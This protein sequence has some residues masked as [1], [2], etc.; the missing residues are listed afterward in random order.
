ML[1]RDPLGGEQERLRASSSSLFPSL[2]TPRTDRPSMID[3]LELGQPVDEAG[4]GRSRS[5]RG[6]ALPVVD[7]V[8][9][10]L[11][12][13]GQAPVEDERGVGRQAQ[14]DLELVEVVAVGR[15]VADERLPGV[16]EARL[17][18]VELELR[19]ARRLALDQLAGRPRRAARRPRCSCGRSRR[20][21]RPRRTLMKP[22]VGS[23]LPPPVNPSDG[24]AEPKFGIVPPTRVATMNSWRNLA[25]ERIG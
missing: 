8:E 7:R 20:S 21:G 13:A 1:Q 18:L 24:T 16:L 22:I 3:V 11:E 9:D 15:P 12:P 17:D 23:L 14:L 25:N 5:R 4:A 6:F 19:Q 2:Y 10:L